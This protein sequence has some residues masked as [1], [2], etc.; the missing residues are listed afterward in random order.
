MTSL[1]AEPVLAYL[2]PASSTMIIT[3][4]LGGFAAFGLV[5]KRFW[6]QIKGLVGRT[7]DEP[8]DISADIDGTTGAQ[9]TD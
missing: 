4:I 1:I 2:D 3:A 5:I 7:K 8:A 9:A 6:Y